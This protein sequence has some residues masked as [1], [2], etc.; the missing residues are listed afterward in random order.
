MLTKELID[1]VKQIDMKITRAQKVIEEKNMKIERLQNKRSKL[2]SKINNKAQTAENLLERFQLNMVEAKAKSGHPLQDPSTSSGELLVPQEK[3][4]SAS[5][6]ATS[7]VAQENIAED[8]PAKH[9]TIFNGPNA[10]CYKEWSTVK[11]FVT[12]KPY[13]YKGYPNYGLARQAFMDY[14]IKNNTHI[15]TTPRLITPTDLLEPKLQKT[16]SFADKA[17]MPANPVVEYTRTFLRFNKIPQ[18]NPDEHEFIPLETFVQY[19]RLAKVSNIIEGCFVSQSKGFRLFNVTEGADPK[20]VQTLFYCGLV[21][22]IYPRANL[23]EISLLP[24]G[25]Y[26]AVKHYR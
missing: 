16:P 2:I 9:C 12:G 17:K 14:C 1:E 24:L 19:Y 20:F 18:K 21:N 10:G 25:I 6:P 4:P 22:M 5:Q 26:A 15:H 13:C 23:K 8:V 3:A 11:P 7:H